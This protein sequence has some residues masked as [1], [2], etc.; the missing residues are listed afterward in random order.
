VPYI[1]QHR[2]Q[3]LAKSP[4]PESVGELNYC[5]TAF[6]R[7]YIKRKQLSYQTINDVLGALEGAKLEFVRRIANDYEDSKIQSNGDVYN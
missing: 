2:R 3:A 7:R 1:T 5:F 4:V 6:I